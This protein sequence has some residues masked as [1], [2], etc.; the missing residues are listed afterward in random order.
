MTSTALPLILALDPG[1]RCGYALGR[2]GELSRSGVV[3]LRKPKEEREIGCGNL[4]AYLD[5]MFRNP[6][7]RPDI[8]VHEEA[9]GIMAWISMCEAMAKNRPTGFKW[10][11]A[12]GVE[13]SHE[14]NGVIIG[15]C[16][17]YGVRR[18]PL[19]RTT[20]LKHFTGKARHGGRDK[21]KIAVINQARQAGLVEHDCKDDDRCDAVAN[22]S[23]A[24]HEFARK[25]V[26]KPVLFGRSA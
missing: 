8:L 2:A 16:Q 23:F 13:S 14:L 11:N 18:E 12:D 21:A 5:M 25:Q 9:T 3:I 24:S 1:R 6:A 19:S 15:M 7:T 17:R 4:I 26:G 20:V 10:Q 22:F